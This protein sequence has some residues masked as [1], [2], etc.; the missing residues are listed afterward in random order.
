MEKRFLNKKVVTGI[1]FGVFAITVIAFSLNMGTNARYKGIGASF[2]PRIY[3][4]LLLFCSIIQMVGGVIQYRKEQTQENKE[5][6]QK[7]SK[8]IRNVGLC[9][10]AIILYFSLVNVLGFI[11]SST[12]FLV[13]LCFLLIPKTVPINRN[14]VA[15][16]VIFA[17]VLPSITFVFFRNV[18]YTPLPTGMIFGI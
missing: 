12:L 5:R 18:V 4:G 9:F 8:D 1:I 16:I 6:E 11:L 13:A 2:M 3:G 7:K 14:L 10:L 17:I 15:E